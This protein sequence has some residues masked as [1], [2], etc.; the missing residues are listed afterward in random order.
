M[1]RTIYILPAF[2][3]LLQGCA[4]EKEDEIIPGISGEPVYAMTVVASKGNDADTR[5][6][7]LDGK[8]LNAAWEAGDK[9]QVYDQDG[10]GLGE[11]TA[12]G[13]GTETL[14]KG[15]LTGPVVDGA[16]LTLKFL[17]PDYAAQEGT[18]EYIAAH[19]DHSIA[20]ITVSGIVDNVV[21]T[22]AAQFENRQAIVKFTLKEVDGETRINADGF[23][24]TA[25]ETAIAVTP[26]SASSE[27][28]VAIPAIED[29][30]IWL[31]ATSSD[32]IWLY[33]YTRSHV[34]FAQG[35][36][37]E[38]GVKMPRVIRVTNEDELNAAVKEYTHV[39]IDADIRLSTTF[40]LDG[41]KT[42]T[43]NL[44]G[45]RLDRGLDSRVDQ[46]GQAVGIRAG[47]SLTLEDSR[48]GGS[49]TGGWGGDGGGIR[50]EGDLTI[51]GC[52]ICDNTA[53]DRGGGISNHGTLT[54]GGGCV[55]TGN[56][57]R[58][59]TSPF[60]GGGIFNHQGAT[61]VMNGVAVRDNKSL[62]YGGGGILNLGTA[63]L[64]NVDVDFN[65]TGYRG[66]GIFNDGSMTIVNASLTGNKAQEGGGICNTMDLSMDNTRLLSNECRENGGGILGLRGTTLTLKG[67]EIRNNF[68]NAGTGGIHSHST[69]N[70]QGLL[71]VHD[72]SNSNICLCDSR[73]LN[74]VG[75]LDPSSSIGITPGL[76][77]GEP[78]TVGFSTHNGTLDPSAVFFSDGSIGE[79][80]LYGG[81]AR[82]LTQGV[83][84]LDNAWEDGRVVGTVKLCTDYVAI[85]SQTSFSGWLY[86]ANN[87]TINNRVTVSGETHLLLRETLTCKKG[88]YVKDGA[89]LHVHTIPGGYGHL[90][91]PGGDGDNA[92]IGGNDGSIGGHVVI[93]GGYVEAR[94]SN[95][96]AAGIGGGNHTSGLRSFTVY[97]GTV[98]AVGK[99]SGA[100]IGSGQQNNVETTVTIYGGKVTATGG[101][102][103]AGIGGGEDRGSG[104]VTIYDGIV[105]ATGGKNGAGIGGGEGGSSG[106]VTIRGGDVTANAGDSAA[107]IGGGKN[108]DGGGNNGLIEIYGGVVHATG[109][110]AIQ[111]GGAGIGCG[112]EG[113]QAGGI[114]IYGGDV[115]A[116]GGNM[117]AG[118]GGGNKSYGGDI[119]IEGGTVEA[120]GGFWAAGIG[121]G[122]EGSGGRIT[123]RQG[124]VQAFARNEIGQ[125]GASLGAGI[126]GGDGG[127]GGDI[128]ITGGIV[129]ANSENGAAIGGGSGGSGNKIEIEDGSVIAIALAG[130]AGIGGGRS[131]QTPGNGSGGTI[132]IRGG[133]VMASGGAK[134]LSYTQSSF[135]ALNHILRFLVNIQ[136]KF[137][138]GGM[139]SGLIKTAAL[140][141]GQAI[142][143]S[144]DDDK[145]GGAGIGGGNTGDGGN[146]TIYG[147]RVIA[148]GGHA[149]S[150]AIGHGYKYKYYSDDLSV[151]SLNLYD[152]AK[153]SAGSSEK[154]YSV[155]R[156]ADRVSA[157]RDNL[158]T[159]IDL[160]DHNYSGDTCIWCGHVR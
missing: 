76:L 18:L 67:C 117:G 116:K 14:L 13:G 114:H 115:Y 19:C 32:V 96:N 102:L 129:I 128:L 74:I 66:G 77:D 50:N 105:V 34:V 113:T 27:L 107:G 152:R 112:N 82:I 46:V 94:A 10:N 132:T 49:I 99:S 124:F 56:T 97:G 7:I 123:I 28:Y 160:C 79:V 86:L 23:S 100:G 106:T 36:Y 64:D 122:N 12:Q 53:D 135:N 156:A 31:S 138:P 143:A 15:T 26:Q 9:V 29:Q 62:V 140:S 33:E 103:A 51:N 121:G 20:E 45:H 88:I 58:D 84:Y 93:H 75:P 110:T 11:L 101:D 24:F 42:V 80:D 35:K 91:C 136:G 142:V 6:L 71:V 154:E 89:T 2:L 38:I 130:G 43:V 1:K 81:E 120:H 118:I 40:I 95:N 134:D 57:S 83:A 63:S 39:R 25:G 37:Y 78:F 109:G 127:D 3:L 5:A 48:G 54:I 90:V 139:Y 22:D 108:S 16:K 147:G 159:V 70:V 69:I 47:S 131:N 72:N 104:P 68:S 61:L 65:Q 98:V 59:Q 155:R 157:C 148:Q 52:I 55:I 153:V 17:S 150:N 92:A 111:K 85:D 158:F 44:N 137:S 146:V 125:S 8:T 21:T 87:K 141:L 126:G 60:G 4:K 144:L 30:T 73:K 151:G 145:W 133:E 119:T 149:G 41:N